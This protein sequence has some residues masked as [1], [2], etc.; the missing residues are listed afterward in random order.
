MPISLEAFM[1]AVAEKM[2]LPGFGANS[3][4]DG[5]HFRRPE[6]LYLRMTANIACAA[7][8]RGCKERVG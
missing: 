1:F 7:Y 2:D 3:F 8:K 5:A 4:G 6:D